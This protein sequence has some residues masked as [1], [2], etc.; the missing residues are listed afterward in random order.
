MVAIPR[1]ALIQF[2]CVHQ[3]T[4]SAFAAQAEKAK[5]AT[6]IQRVYRGRL[7]RARLESKRQ[8]DLAAK[9][10]YGYVDANAL[11]VA[12]VKELARRIIYAIEVL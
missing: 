6:N 11:L 2:S 4:S 3:G 10:A 9:E 7:G 5:A 1:G 12:D 8:L